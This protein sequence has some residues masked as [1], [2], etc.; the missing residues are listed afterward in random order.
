G[1]GQ[2]RERR[3]P[4]RPPPPSGPPPAKEASLDEAEDALEGAL[5]SSGTGT[6]V[7][8]DGGRLVIEVL[9]DQTIDW[10]ARIVALIVDG[11]GHRIETDPAGTTMP[12]VLAA[13][14]TARIVLY[15][16][17]DRP[18]GLRMGAREIELR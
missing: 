9:F 14:Q 17:G 18:H 7:L 5:V 10:D 12:C 13:G 3:M 2:E 8:H 1:S 16:S 15:W 11:V 4:R 6:I